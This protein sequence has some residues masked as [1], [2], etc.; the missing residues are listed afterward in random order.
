MGVL[1]LRIASLDGSELQLSVPEHILGIEVL[2]LVRA[3]LPPKP[4]V[5]QVFFG[6][7][8]REKSWPSEKRGSPLSF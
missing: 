2:R 5:L 6:E 7:V 8:T 3:Q 4:G 1:E